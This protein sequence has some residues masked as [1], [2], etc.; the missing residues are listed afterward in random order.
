MDPQEA[1]KD[2]TISADSQQMD[3][4]TYHLRGHVKVVYKDIRVTADEASFDDASGE[5]IA[6]GNVVFDDPT[7]PSC[8]G[9]SP[10]QHPDSK[11][12]V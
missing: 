11:G 10:L 7:E 4:G 2:A 9:R 6:R 12:M 5:V 1:G 8:R 3:K